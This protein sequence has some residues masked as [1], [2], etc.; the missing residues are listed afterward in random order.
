M[1]PL[2]LP[3]ELVLESGTKLVSPRESCCKGAFRTPFSLSF[4]LQEAP[5]NDRFEVAVPCCSLLDMSANVSLNENLPDAL[6]HCSLDLGNAVLESRLQQ[7]P[8]ALLAAM[9]FKT[10]CSTLDSRLPGLHSPET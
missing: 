6:L 8:P 9:A 10:S 7:V 5:K 2:L 3:K 1:N 4:P